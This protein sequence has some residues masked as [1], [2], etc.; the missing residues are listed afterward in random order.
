MDEY[1]MTSGE[2]PG[3]DEWSFPVDDR[4]GW[5]PGAPSLRALA[6]SAVG[7][8]AIPV[9][10]YFLV[11]PHVHSDA[12]ALAIAGIPACLWVAFE[13][14][15]KRAIDPIGVI[16]LTGFALGLLVSWALGGN[17]FVLKVRDSAFTAGFGLICL[18]SLR[19]ERP[20]MFYIGRAMSAGVDA[21][22]RR[23]YDRLWEMA[24]SRA[25]FRILTGVWAVGLLAD[26]GCR[27][28]A[29]VVLPTSAFVVVSPVLSAIFL[30]GLFAFTLWFS[31]WARQR[32]ESAMDLQAPPDGG[33]TWW[34]V[35]QFLPS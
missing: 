2:Q 23:L 15:R 18:V 11:R 7:G 19:A 34:W 28:I 30:G 25:I 8:A 13:W 1:A 33:S 6:P 5:E 9:A 27:V 17:A 3:E 22:K 21:V 29:A 35:R 4:D 12:P 32:A 16:V 24:P 20:M 31:Q 26:A 14:V 10:V